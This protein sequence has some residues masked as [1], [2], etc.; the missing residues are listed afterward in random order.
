[1][2]LPAY[3]AESRDV[4]NG[5]EQNHDI[6]MGCRRR[7]LGLLF[8]SVSKAHIFVH[9]PIREDQFDSAATITNIKLYGKYGAESCVRN[10]FCLF[11]YMRGQ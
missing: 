9:H 6:K 7:F 11:I 5:F 2:C 1:M 4:K 3:E 8:F 10:S